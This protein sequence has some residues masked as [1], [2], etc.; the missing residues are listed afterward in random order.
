MNLK[1]FPANNKGSLT[2]AQKRVM[3]FIL[4]NSEEAAFMTAS[5]LSRKAGVSEATVVRLARRL[6]FS[7][8]PEMQGAL[9]EN[10]QTRLSTVTRIEKTVKKVR[11]T[12]DVLTKVMQEDIHNL[13]QTLLDISVEAFKHAVTDMQRARRIFVVG[14]RG[15]HAPA[16]MLALYLKFIKKET[17]LLV[18]GIE[19]IWMNMRNVGP[20]DLVIGI[21]F[22]RYTRMTVEILEFAAQKKTRVGAITDSLLSPLTQNA[23]WVLTVRS[24]LDSY[25]ESFTASMSLVNALLTALSI[26]QPETMEALEDGERIWQ[27]KGIYF[28]DSRA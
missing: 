10:L 26:Q 2:A 11:N 1:N 6:E 14:L 8:Y 7:G 21:S 4:K 17:H 19:D 12:E 13:S 18:P 16:L 22:P 15:S 27:D 3:T 20:D 5:H 24:E 25:I 23:D 9:R 28:N